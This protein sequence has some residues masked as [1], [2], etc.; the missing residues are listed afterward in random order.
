MDRQADMYEETISQRDGYN[1]RQMR[2]QNQAE[3][4]I[5]AKEQVDRWKDRKVRMDA[6]INRLGQTD[7]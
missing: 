2:T 5:D 4:Q 7:K 1:A 3:E 6:G